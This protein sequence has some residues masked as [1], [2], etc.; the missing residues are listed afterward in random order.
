V[1][2]QPTSA[3]VVAIMDD[4]SSSCPFCLNLREDRQLSEDLTH[5][6]WAQGLISNTC[7]TC[8]ILVKCIEIFKPDMLEGSSLD[9]ECGISL[10]IKRDGEIWIEKMPFQT[11]GLGDSTN[12]HVNPINGAA[13]HFNNINLTTP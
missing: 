2:A 13:I 9:P 7:A 11:S 10:S 12:F 5:E 4:S 1:F 8:R 6:A 3:S